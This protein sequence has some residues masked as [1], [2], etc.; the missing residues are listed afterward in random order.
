MTNMVLE[1]SAEM[2]EAVL[3]EYEADNPGRT[4]GSMTSEEFGRRMMRKIVA[5]ARPRSDPGHA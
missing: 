1:F 3:R 2:V 4:A 5:S